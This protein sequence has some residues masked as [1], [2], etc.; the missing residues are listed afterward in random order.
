MH[1]AKNTEENSHFL[2]AKAYYYKYI[3]LPKLLYLF[4]DF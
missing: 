2:H 4:N 3:N 1:R